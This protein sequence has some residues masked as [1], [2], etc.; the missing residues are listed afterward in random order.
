MGGTRPGPR[1][2]L[3]GNNA[4][5]DDGRDLETNRPGY[6]D[7]D[8]GGCGAV[9]FT[10]ESTEDI[11]IMFSMLNRTTTILILLCALRVL[12]VV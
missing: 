7:R 5:D 8:R 9:V 11:E 6:A 4:G 12:C 2:I 1:R 3:S 10:T